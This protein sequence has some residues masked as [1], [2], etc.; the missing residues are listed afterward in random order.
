[1]LRKIEIE[2]IKAD[3]MAEVRRSHDFQR[4][5]LR[6]MAQDKNK[7]IEKQNEK[8]KSMKQLH[9]L[10][11]SEKKAE[12]NHYKKQ[13]FHEVKFMKKNLAEEK[14]KIDIG[15][16]LEKAMKAEIVRS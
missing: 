6:D 14:K 2:R 12:I 5:M 11:H 7:W 9:S 4:A 10:Y 3:K 15:V 13:C 1:M 8:N 16:N